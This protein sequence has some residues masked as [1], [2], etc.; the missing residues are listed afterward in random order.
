MA[1]SAGDCIFCEIV[2]R[3]APASIVREDASTLAFMDIQPMNPGHVLVI[4]KAHAAYIEDLPPAAIGP[5]LEASKEISRALRT[6]GIRCEAVSF[7]LANGKEAGQEVFHTHMHVIPRW[8]G[9]GLGLRVRADRGRV[10]DRKE[11]DTL[12]AKIR[13]AMDLSGS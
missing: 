2:R 10:A 4:P 8:R 13:A 5:I 7:Y 6:S 12:A 3:G 11:L 1:A 9:D